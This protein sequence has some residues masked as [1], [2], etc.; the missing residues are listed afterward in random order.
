MFKKYCVFLSILLIA[1]CAPLN[2][3]EQEQI[4]LDPELDE[5]TSFRMNTSLQ[6]SD[7]SYNYVL[8]QDADLKPKIFASI[9]DKLSDK[10]YGTGRLE[11]ALTLKE[12]AELAAMLDELTANQV[13]SFVAKY[14]DCMINGM[15]DYYGS[16]GISFPEM[17]QTANSVWTTDI[18]HVT[19]KKVANQT[20]KV[21]KVISYDVCVTIPK[22]GYMIKESVKTRV[23]AGLPPGQEGDWQKDFQFLKNNAYGPGTVCRGFDHQTYDQDRLLVITVDYKLTN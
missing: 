7:T 20:D 10:G 3:V 1:G 22:N 17:P 9:S 23:I 13:E 8:G 15:G 2:S 5:E 21:G 16:K 4:S 11:I 14:E 6:C 19:G 18:H 12:K